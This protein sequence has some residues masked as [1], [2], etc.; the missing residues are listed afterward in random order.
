MLKALRLT[1]YGLTVF[2]LSIS[3]SLEAQ[4]PQF[5][6]FEIQ[7]GFRIK[8]IS[9][10]VQDA[11]G[12]IWFGSREGVFRYD[13]VNFTNFNSNNR[14]HYIPINIVK[15]ILVDKEEDFIIIYNN[16]QVYEV[17][18]LQ[19]QHRQIKI[20]HPKLGIGTKRMMEVHLDGKGGLWAINVQ[21]LSDYLGYKLSIYHSSNRDSFRLVKELE[22][23]ALF[24]QHFSSAKNGYLYVNFEQSVIA[25]APNGKVLNRYAFPRGMPGGHFWDE[26]ETLW[27]ITNIYQHKKSREPNIKA[28][29]KGIFYLKKGAQN[30]QEFQIEDLSLLDQNNQLYVD[31]RRLLTYKNRFSIIDR[32]TRTGKKYYRKISKLEN[33]GLKE[34]ISVQDVFQDLSGVYWL[35]GNILKN[36]EFDLVEHIIQG[37]DPFCNNWK[38][39]VRKIIE[40]EKGNIVFGTSHRVLQYNPQTT[41]VTTLDCNKNIKVWDTWGLTLQHPYLYVD[42]RR[43]NLEDCTFNYIIGNSKKPTFNAL[44]GEGNLW[45][46]EHSST[47]SVYNIEKETVEPFYALKDTLGDKAVFVRSIF[48][49]KKGP[50]VWVLTGEH[51]LYL[52][53]L[54]KGIVAQYTYD[55]DNENSM[56]SPQLYDVFETE[57][58]NLWI[59][60]SMGLSKLETTTNTFTHYKT[61]DG[62]P[63]SKV[64]SILP[65]S[66]KGLW[67]GKAYGICFLD[68]SSKFSKIGDF[69]IFESSNS[70]FAH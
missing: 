21:T 61:E 33:F 26:S 31:E 12:N 19:N 29:E 8:N 15:K 69:E 70:E 28:L 62:L 68:F 14:K 7:K 11:A 2:Y 6:N 24:F 58:G 48:P 41:A 4:T 53:H 5:S 43:V 52:L 63:T 22:T 59:G 32:T 42:N 23:E 39:P 47:I 64:Y 38:C 17:D 51:G 18:P 57:D 65:E 66:D 60:S 50:G 27:M 36:L 35:S 9:N 55:P 56:P 25:L 16:K 10:V 49:R 46:G 1:K 45:L 13:G 30:F 34:R 40:D 37:G 44:D 67:L 3:I 54:E 20:Q